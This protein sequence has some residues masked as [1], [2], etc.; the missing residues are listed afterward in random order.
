MI[1]RPLGVALLAVALLVPS[2]VRGQEALAYDLDTIDPPRYALG[3]AI[4]ERDFVA[5]RDGLTSLAVDIIRPDTEDAVPTILIQSPYYNTLGRGYSG[6]KKAPW[7]TPAPSALLDASVRVPFPEWYDEYFVPRGYAVVLQDQRGTRNSS[8]CQ[9]YGG[10]EEITDAVDVIEW[11]AAQPWSNG[12]VGMT[13]GSYDGT[14]AIGAASMAPPAL[15]AII[16]IRAIS[17]WYEYHFFNG[18]QSSQHTLTPLSF[19]SLRTAEDTQD[20]GLHDPL[21]GLHVVERKAC[22]V[23]LG[24]AVAAQYSLPV[25]DSTDPFW[26]ARDYLIDVGN[27]EAA[28]FIIHGLEDSNVKPMQAGHLWSGLRRRTPKMLWWFRGGHAD[29]A[30]P[31]A[32]EALPYPFNE[33]FVDATHRWFARYL[34]GID[35]GVESLPP[36]SIQGEGGSWRDATRWPPPRGDRTYFFTPDGLRRSAWG[37]TAVISTAEPFVG[38]SLLL[39]T[40]RFRGSKRLAGQAFVRLTYE[41]PAGGDATFAASLVR[42]NAGDGSVT[43][44]ARGY[45]R[46]GHRDQI[47]RRGPSWPTTIREHLPGEVATIAF[48]LWPMDARIRRGD[49]LDLYLAVDDGATYGHATGADVIIHLNGASKLVVPIAEGRRAEQRRARDRFPERW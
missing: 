41:L 27:I 23:S 37:D 17:R 44:I 48:P 5:A 7:M 31:F 39:A 42:L 15:K 6:Q 32:S 47:Q 9:V 10:R 45:A 2:N 22:A 46:A 36:V 49:V 26:A 24:A 25:Q 20:A 14:V 38:D 19:T 3:D 29:P 8:G 16:P 30:Q 13:G 21:L 28:T 12:A 40:K 1:V 35:S 33:R 34:K 4:V 11:I 43:E 18:V